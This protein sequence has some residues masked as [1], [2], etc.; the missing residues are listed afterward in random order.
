MML[1]GLYTLQG[2]EK[3]KCTT[4]DWGNYVWSIFTIH[5]IYGE[6]E[7][8][9]LSLPQSGTGD[10]GISLVRSCETWE[11]FFSEMICCRVMKLYM[12]DASILAIGS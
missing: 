12:L 7:V 1:L 2:A 10:I 9:L 8:H 3:L 5:L 4:D 11:Q 6:M